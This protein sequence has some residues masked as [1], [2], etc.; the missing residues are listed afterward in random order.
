MCDI[1]PEERLN[2]EYVYNWLKPFKEEINSLKKF[3]SGLPVVTNMKKY[4]P[5]LM[6]YQQ[7]QPQVMYSQPLNQGIKVQTNYTTSNERP[8]VLNQ[9]PQYQ[10]PPQP[11]NYH[12]PQYQPAT[13]QKNQ[14]QVP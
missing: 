5:F 11:A 7:P 14:N 2:S 13:I 1:N 10:P 8:V 9:A 12:Q 3:Q 6:K 4:E